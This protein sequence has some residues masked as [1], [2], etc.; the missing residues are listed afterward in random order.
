MK[1]AE[2][3]DF[4]TDIVRP[5]D[6]GIEEKNAAAIDP[7][8]YELTQGYRDKNGRWIDM[9][10]ARP[11]SYST[12]INFLVNDPSDVVPPE[13][14][15]LGEMFDFDDERKEG[16]YISIPVEFRGIT[17]R[18]LHAILANVRRRCVTERWMAWRDN[19]GHKLVK[20]IYLT[21]ETVNLY[22]VN[23]FII[24]P[25]TKISGKSLVESLPSTGGS[26]PPRWFVSHWWGEVI[27]DFM[28]CLEA[29]MR[30]FRDNQNADD[31]E[32]G[33]G[34]TEDSPVWICSYAN[35]QNDLGASNMENP[36]ESSFVKAMSV[37]NFRTIAM[38]D[39]KATVLTRIWVILELYMTLMGQVDNKEGS[40]EDIEGLWAVYTPFQHTAKYGHL[41]EERGA[42]GIV[43]GG[44]PGDYEWVEYTVKRELYFPS[45]LIAKS[46]N[47]NVV[48]AKA[49]APSDYNTIL[50]FIR[51]SRENLSAVP[52]LNDPSYTA[53]N[54]AVGSNFARTPAV[55]QAAFR[56]GDRDLWTRTLGLMSKNVKTTSMKLNFALGGGWDDI[57][58]DATGELIRHLP[59]TAEKLEIWMS[60]YGS[61]LVDALIKWIKISNNLTA[62]G[63]ERTTVGGK[64]GGRDAGARLA[65]ALKRKNAIRTFSFKQTDLVGSRN[66]TEWGEAI[67]EMTM[68]KS[69]TICGM[70]QYIGK[71]DRAIAE[72]TMLKSLTICG[73]VQYIAKVNRDTV[74]DNFTIANP[75]DD[76]QRVYFNVDDGLFPDGMLLDD[77]SRQMAKGIGRNSSI[78]HINFRH[79]ASGEE[80]VAAFRDALMANHTITQVTF[81]AHLSEK[82]KYDTKDRIP[83]IEF[84]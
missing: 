42:V 64:D 20:G 77:G 28:A 5:L 63:I 9:S 75:Q 62:L 73:I 41:I 24:I 12:K 65:D 55:L 14:A 83:K 57:T 82:L 17:F 67:A 23:E 49:S 11:C 39:R 60:P 50:N 1:I 25:F 78:K 45:H 35:N 13:T 53:L 47:I 46:T 3:A 51:G 48:L 72:M 32:R 30:D 10:I 34:V 58:E 6:D 69:L 36:G 74:D 18:Q 44:V 19:E 26:Q 52:P 71:V 38:L 16:G 15:Q 81:R 79:H 43:P 4:T 54:E 7:I 84:N 8:F 68:L 21:P 80:G 29:H 31:D 70:G 27:V 76:R 33:G 37:S 40:V 22:H 59:I 56:E 2:T 66:A 61:T